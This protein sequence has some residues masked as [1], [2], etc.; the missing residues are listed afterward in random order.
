VD[1]GQCTVDR[2]HGRSRERD[3]GGGGIAFEGKCMAMGRQKAFFLWAVGTTFLGY[4]VLF[5]KKY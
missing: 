1:S 5:A 3:L 2:D 4:G